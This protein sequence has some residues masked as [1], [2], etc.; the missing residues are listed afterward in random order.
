MDIL[1]EQLK[2]D[3]QGDE[4]DD[5]ENGGRPNDQDAE[6]EEL[7]RELNELRNFV[8]ANKECI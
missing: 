8:N 4:I 3:G 2:E 1:K 6:E 5:E 7:M